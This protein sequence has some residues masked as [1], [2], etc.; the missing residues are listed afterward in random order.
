MT[1]PKECV[2][3]PDGKTISTGSTLWTKC[4]FQVGMRL[5]GSVCNLEK[6]EAKKDE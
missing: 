6:K 5:I 3:C 4:R 2:R 1:L